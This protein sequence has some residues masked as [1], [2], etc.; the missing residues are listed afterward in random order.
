MR[1]RLGMSFSFDHHC[2]PLDRQGQTWFS[3][4]SLQSKQQQTLVFF[5]FSKLER[6]NSSS[7]SLAVAA[8]FVMN[9]FVLLI[10][11]LHAA[12]HCICKMQLM[13]ENYL[14]TS[15]IYF[16]KKIFLR[17]TCLKLCRLISRFEIRFT[18]FLADLAHSYRC[19]LTSAD[20]S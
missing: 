14:V 10:M 6:A 16:L 18:G 4:L 1:T 9:T 2:W 20:F 8:N 3:V 13:G 19:D 7:S 11:Y 5:F 12:S 15:L 17:V